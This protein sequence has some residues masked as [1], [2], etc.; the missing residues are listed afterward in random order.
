MA[1]GWPATGILRSG[2]GVN[3][4][5][6]FDE[7]DHAQPRQQMLDGQVTTRAVNVGPR[8]RE[9]QWTAYAHVG[10]EVLRGGMPITPVGWKRGQGEEAEAGGKRERRERR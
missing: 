1:D 3:Q 9:Q 4:Q 2:G 8:S 7:E 5:T 10:E 6:S